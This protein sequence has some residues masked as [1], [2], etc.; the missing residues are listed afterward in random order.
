LIAENNDL[1]RQTLRAMKSMAV[2]V[3]MDRNGIAIM[4]NEF[5]D[6]M[7]IDKRI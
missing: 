4:V 7:E 1:Q 5:L 2:N 3:N 6:Q